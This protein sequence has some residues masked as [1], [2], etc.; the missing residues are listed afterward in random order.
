MKVADKIICLFLGHYYS[1]F[2]RRNSSCVYC[3]T[4]QRHRNRKVGNDV[5][6]RSIANEDLSQ[7]ST[8]EVNDNANL[9][10]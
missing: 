9:H 1:R 2:E 8:E 4:S 7:P 5:D 10:S 3:G 6:R